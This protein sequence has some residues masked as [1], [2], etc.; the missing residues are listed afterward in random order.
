[1]KLKLILILALSL[2]LLACAKKDLNPT[3][4]ISAYD[5][6]LLSWLGH[7]VNEVIA[8]WGR[9][10]R[11]GALGTGLK[12]YTWI[13]PLNP[14]EAV[15]IARD[16]QKNAYES[17]QAVFVTDANGIIGNFN[18]SREDNLSKSFGCG[19]LKPP[20]AAYAPKADKPQ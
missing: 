15:F 19:F 6:A 17:C 12:T 11:T 10:T 8:Q 2:G 18:P 5:R 16:G 20:P 9:P 14:A 13:W 4:S 3:Y 7:P 1:M